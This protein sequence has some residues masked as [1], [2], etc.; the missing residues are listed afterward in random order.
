MTHALNIEKQGTSSKM[1]Q[2]RLPS[3]PSLTTPP[4][5]APHYDRIVLVPV[6]YVTALCRPLVDNDHHN[7]VQARFGTKSL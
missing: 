1:N 2:C 4:V 5:R 3:L 7:Q 6:D